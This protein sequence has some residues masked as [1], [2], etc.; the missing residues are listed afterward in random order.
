MDERTL[1]SV[2]R[3]YCKMRPFY[4]SWQSADET[5]YYLKPILKCDSISASRPLRMYIRLDLGATWA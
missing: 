1:S 3:G 5:L 4:S 2:G